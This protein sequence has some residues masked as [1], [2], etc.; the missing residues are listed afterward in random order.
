MTQLHN[1]QSHLV[2]RYLRKGPRNLNLFYGFYSNIS[3]FLRAYRMLNVL[4]SY[5]S[6]D[7]LCVRPTDHH[8][9]GIS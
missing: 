5:R 1:I 2:T 7:L 8:F 4:L 6:F 9:N 3:Y